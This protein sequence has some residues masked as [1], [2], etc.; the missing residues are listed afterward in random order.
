[1]IAHEVRNPRRITQ[2]AVC[3]SPEGAG[4]YDRLYALSDYGEVWYYSF[5]TSKWYALA[6]LPDKVRTFETERENEL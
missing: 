4:G 6:G 5:D 3:G 2:I 1:M